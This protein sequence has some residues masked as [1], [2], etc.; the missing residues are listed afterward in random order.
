VTLEELAQDLAGGRTTAVGLAENALSAIEQQH[1]QDIPAFIYVNQDAVLAE[2]RESDRRRN[3]GRA[4]SR[5]DGVPF[6]VKDLFDVKG[7][8]TTAGSLLLKDEKPAA[9]DSDAVELLRNKGLVVLGRTNMTEFAYSGVGLNPH[10]GTP[11]SVY[12]RK[13]GRIPGGS[14]SGSAVAVADGVC[15]MALGTDTGGS[16]RIPAAFNGISGFKPTASRISKHGVFPLSTLLDSIGTLARSAACC[17]IADDILA[18]GEGRKSSWKASR[19][20]KL[21]ILKTHMMDGLAPEVDD[22]FQRTLKLLG[23]SAEVSILEFPALAELQSLLNN[24][25]I[26]AYEA[27]HLHKQWLETRESEYD[28]RVASRIRFGATTD[29][30][31]FAQLLDRRSALIEEFQR[32][33]SEFDAILCP[34]SL[35]PPPKLSELASDDEYRRLN[36]MALRNTYVFNFLDGCAGSIPM[37]GEGEP[38][39]GLMLAHA[40]NQDRQ[41]LAVMQEVERLLQ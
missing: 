22:A 25:G 34:T 5:F 32:F 10:Y 8:V 41:L 40:S 26:V 38:P 14:S 3:E 30:S 37:Q 29:V 12:D 6:A 39:M 27:W 7:Q 4:L 11:T 9:A 13:A 19:P 17:A 18:G 35:M 2:A 36:G 20:L 24:G 33:A 15:A 28:P 31:T 21:A 1:A 23:K 16:C